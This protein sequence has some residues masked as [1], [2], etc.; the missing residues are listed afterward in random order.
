MR[1][2]VLGKPRKVELGVAIA[3]EE[4]SREIFRL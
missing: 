3:R 4:V 1:I 2:G